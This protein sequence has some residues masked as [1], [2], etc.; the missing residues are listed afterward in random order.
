MAK[1]GSFI[2]KLRTAQ[3]QSASLL[4]VGL[5]PDPMRLPEVVTRDIPVHEAVLRFC[6][7][8][9]EATW[10]HACGFKVNFAFFE[11]LGSEGWNVL[12]EVVS[13]IPESRIRIAD[14]KRG[15]IGNTGRFYAEAIL[16]RMNFDACTV[17]PYMGRSSVQP[18]LKYRGK[19]AFVLALTSNPDAAEIQSWP[20]Q[21]SPLYLHVAERAVGW[22]RGE[23]GGVGLVVGGTDTAGLAAVRRVCPEAP[24]LVPG[25]GA[26]GGDLR[27][28]LSSGLTEQGTLLINSSRGI[29]YSGSGDDYAARAADAA[30]A[31]R[32]EIHAAAAG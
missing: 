25:I 11:A 7:D 31:L 24:F 9:I 1:S 23:P 17:S 21:G 14:A 22:G 26:Q 8:I 4:C 5:D 32:D 3:T 29:L 16:G 2:E 18:F 30:Q 19:G 13:A 6:L 12:E 10:H 20:E 15:D 28:V 27:G